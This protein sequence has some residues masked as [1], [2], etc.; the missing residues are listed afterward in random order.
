MYSAISGLKGNQTYMD[1][2]GNNISNVN[3]TAYKSDAATFATTLSQA[4]RPASAPTATKG[5]INPLQVGLGMKL[6]SINTDFTQGDL[7]STGRSSDL[8]VDGN[9]F[10]MLSDGSQR[11]YTRDGSFDIGTDGSLINSSTGFKVQGWMAT[12][13][14]IDTT[15]GLTS[16]VLPI[17]G[18]AAAVPTSKATFRGNLDS[19]ATVGDTF[20]T[21]MEFYDALGAQ[22]TISVT[23]TKTAANTWGWAATV[24]T[25][26]TTIS[27]LTGATGSITF[28][29]T[30]PNI[31]KV[32]AGGTG[33]IGVT[34]STGKPANSIAVDYSTIS[35]YAQEGEVNMTEQNGAGPGSF[36]SYSIDQSGIISALYSNGT[37]NDVGQIALARFANIGGLMK[38]GNNAYT[39]SPNSGTAVIAAAGTSGLGTINSCY[40]ESGNVDL[41]QQFTNMIVASRGF[42][43]N[44]RVITTSDEMLQ[45]LV[46]LKR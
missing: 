18:Q 31:G 25:S 30:A 34:Y 39:T 16:L 33:T 15:Q 14:V 5:G 23:Y 1:V 41:A 26:E 37:R 22:H 32:T 12:N 27:G 40:L 6:Q 10:F 35:Q 8:A 28:G 46:N 9:G 38:A 24:P 36:L 13:G 19:E 45:E 2:I 17:N 4:L 11:L 42:Q 44:S 21:N 20:T 43:A 29:T 7:K 3:T